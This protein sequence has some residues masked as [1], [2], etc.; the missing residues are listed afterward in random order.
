MGSLV[1]MLIL[2]VTLYGNTNGLEANL[3][4][5]D[6]RAIAKTFKEEGIVISDTE[7]PIYSN[8]SGKVIDLPAQEGQ[9]V[10]KGDL[11]VVINSRELSF[12]LEQL[13]AQLKSV[14][15]EDAQIIDKQLQIDQAK[16]HLQTAETNHE[17]IEQLYKAGAISNVEYEEAQ[18]TV[19]SAENSL[20]QI[21]ESFTGTK[22]YYAGMKESL[23]A[24][25][26]LINHQI[27]E[28][29][30]YA[31]I[32]GVVAELSIKKDTILNP[33]TPI[34]TIF[35]EDSYV[36][37]VLVLTEDATKIK[38]GMKVQLLQNNKDEDIQFEGIVEKIAPSAIEKVSTLGLVEQRIKVTVRPEIPETLI[39]RPGYVLDAQFSTDQKENQLV[40]PKTALFPY[41]DG[42]ALWMVQNGK[43]K[44]QPV[45][46]GFEN[47][48]DVAI[49]K[50]LQD[51]D[52]VI[53][54]PQLEGLKEG[55]K[56]IA[57]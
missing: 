56:I 4:K 33:N 27:K 31:P 48:K 50:G 15:G 40:V 24:Q 25:I 14:Q 53:L 23:N 43:A 30:I 11:L 29:S 21:S 16:Q 54:N 7:I 18:N 8:Y 51:G 20:K 32:D 52:L 12:Q 39:L 2:I 19:K 36:I 3:L 45:Q 13:K 6:I 37:E 9:S 47:E 26:D 44:V 42:D 22:Q 28:S 38:T 41:Q 1:A 57:K 10:T 5:V 46:K 55:K 17:R 49:T 35:Q 34:M